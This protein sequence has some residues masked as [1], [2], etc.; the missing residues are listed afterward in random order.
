[1]DNNGLCR[2]LKEDTELMK[3]KYPKIKKIFVDGK[4]RFKWKVNRDT[5]LLE[6]KNPVPAGARMQIIYKKQG[7]RGQDNDG[8][9]TEQTVL[10]KKVD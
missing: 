5:G 3:H 8:A 2:E 9:Q 4:R 1:M 6:F 10:L 7:K